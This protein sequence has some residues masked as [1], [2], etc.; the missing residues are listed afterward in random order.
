MA[1]IKEFNRKNLVSFCAD[2]EKAVSTVAQKYGVAVKP[3]AGRFSP[4][5]FTKKFEFFTGAEAGESGTDIKFKANITYADLYGMPSIK[6]TDYNKLFTSQGQIYRFVGI[7][8]KGR[9]FPIIAQNMSTKKY[10]KFT[11]TTART[12]S[13][14]DKW[15]K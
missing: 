2:V 15:H 8:P 1:V 6:E 9:R 10:H 4:N 3:A 14:S 11:E 12:I 7:N 5:E 13:D